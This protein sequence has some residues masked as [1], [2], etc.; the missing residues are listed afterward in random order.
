[1]I[2]A[3]SISIPASERKPFSLPW[4]L[5]AGA[6][7]L[8][9]APL[10]VLHLRGLWQKEQYQYFPFVIGAIVWLVWNRWKQAP[11]TP[12]NLTGNHY[13]ARILLAGSLFLLTA[14]VLLVSPWLAM[15]SLNLGL[16]AVCVILRRQ[17]L[18]PYLWGIWLLLWLMIPVPLGL[19]NRL[20]VFLQRLS[21]RL[22]STILDSMGIDHLM[23]GNVLT[24]T[25]KQLFVDEACSG[26][27]SVM[28]IVACAMIYAVW[29]NRSFLH[30]V[31]LTL[32]GIFWA[33]VL[34]VV[35]ICIIAAAHVHYGTDLSSGTPHEILGLILFSVMFLVLMSTDCL[36]L[37]MFA[38]I[39]FQHSDSVWEKNWLVRA[40]NHGISG[41]EAKSAG[42]TSSPITSEEMPRTLATGIPLALL[43]PFLLLGIVQLLWLPSTDTAEAREAIDHALALQEDFVPT[44]IGPW[45]LDSFESVEREA[46][47]DFGRHS[48]TYHFRHQQNNERVIV[49][50]DFPYIGGWHDLCVCYRNAGWTIHDRLLQSRGDSSQEEAWQHVEGDLLDPAGDRAFV[51]FAGFDVQGIPATPTSDL[52]LYRSWFRMRRRLLYNLAPQLFQVQVFFQGDVS[53]HESMKQELR[54]LLFH[55]RQLFRDHVAIKS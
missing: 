49:S 5:V 15:V 43:T 53:T 42:L 2:S 3:P 48:R 1:M 39:D 47:S 22:S 11:P 41:R 4:L 31:M 40:W 44:K 24:L 17:R 37:P 35:R 9:H 52:V 10:V 36:L 51:L 55:V 32:T 19:D 46:Y 50:L 38:P 16:A 28:S 45:E 26:I 7:L 13:F 25:D 29:R 12:D 27:V 54:E 18:I 23:G 14:S 34:N 21:S 33:V 30:L 20:V 8:G 6:I